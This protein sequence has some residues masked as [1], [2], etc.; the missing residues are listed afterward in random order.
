M[1]YISFHNTSLFT[2]ICTT[3]KMSYKQSVVENEKIVNEL[4]IIRILINTRSLFMSYIRSWYGN[5]IRACVRVR[6][7]VIIL[8][9]SSSSITVKV[10]VHRL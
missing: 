9:S 1:T 7:C 6:V 5:C 2:E 8:L 4:Y 10:S 3:L